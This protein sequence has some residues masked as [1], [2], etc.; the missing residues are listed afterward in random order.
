MKN[1]RFEW[2]THKN[3]SN[4]LKHKITFEEAK[5]VFFDENAIQYFD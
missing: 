1:I 5:S 4:Y 3:K 2:D